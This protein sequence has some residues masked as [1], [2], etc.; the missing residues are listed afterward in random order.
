MVL[1]QRHLGDEIGCGDQLRLGVA[2][3][4]GNVKAGPARLQCG[5]D[6]VQVEIVIT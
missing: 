4:D 2:A 6:G 5:D 3:G 1:H